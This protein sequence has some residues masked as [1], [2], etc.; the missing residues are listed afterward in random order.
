MSETTI[1]PARVLYR[2]LCPLLRAEDIA[3]IEGVHPATMRRH[4]QVLSQRGLVEKVE[5]GTIANSQHTFYLTQAGLV[6]VAR[7][8]QVEPEALARTRGADETSILRLL[9]RL[10]TLI[11]TQNFIRHLALF[12]P[13]MLCYPN[14][15][16]ANLQFHWVRDWSHAFQWKGHPARVEVSASLV[17][18]RLAR[19]NEADAF[20]PVFLLADGGLSGTTDRLIIER[21]LEQLLRYR[22]SAE[23]TLHY[24]QFPPVIVIVPT[25]H[26]REHWQR[27]ALEVAEDLRLDPL[28]GAIACVPPDQADVSAWTLAWQGLSN[29]TPCRLQEYLIPM[30]IEALPDGFLPKREV[31]EPNLKP[32]GASKRLLVRGHYAVRSKLEGQGDEAVAWL[33]IRLSHRQQ[34]LLNTLYAAP[35][36]S[37][38]EIA[39]LFGLSEPTTTRALYDLQQAGCI[40]REATEAGKR[41]RLTTQ[42]L[43]LMAAMLHVRLAH[44][45]EWVEGKPVQ[46]GLLVLRRTMRHTAG[47]YDFLARL[48]RAAQE[49]GHQISWWETGGWCERNYRDHGGLR[50][51]RPDAALEYRTDSRRVRL[52]LEWDRGQM[53][54]S[55]LE[56]K[57]FAYA[58]YVHSREW[59][60]ELRP[61]P[62]LLVVTPDPGHEQR[63][64]RMARTCAEEGLIV[65]TTTTSR[66]AEHSP[67]APIWL[68]G[69]AGRQQAQRQSWLMSEPPAEPRA[70]S[71][72]PAGAY[73]TK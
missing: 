24:A 44:V 62:T 16:R 64:Q 11:T 46:R 29:H 58:H 25:P 53:G 4:L 32:V 55:A 48:H 40:E 56:K 60:R 23:R 70:A 28:A 22:E 12:A 67:L 18:R 59:A 52:W 35:L 72:Q 14:G 49:S 45:A 26:Q 20:F 54:S 71:S 39:A 61:L 5:P 10:S 19:Q 8:L 6:T 69:V 57:F 17:F 3:I 27:V 43:R 50:S 68:T 2:L 51:L 21:K 66:L 1:T 30:S 73:A 15:Y 47:V 13:D 65:R 7:Q 63:I 36:L 9:P 41:W 33:G 42:G 37:T 38:E 31:G 34:T